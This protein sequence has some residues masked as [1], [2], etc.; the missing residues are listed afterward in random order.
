MSNAIES[1][2]DE[3]R[4]AGESPALL[5]MCAEGA[6]AHAKM[7]EAERDDLQERLNRAI[8]ILRGMGQIMRRRRDGRA[9]A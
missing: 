8:D 9:P 4:C 7:V 3:L 2:V 6:I 5:K 1:Y